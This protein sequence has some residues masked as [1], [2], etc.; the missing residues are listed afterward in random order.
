MQARTFE[1]AHKEW[2][3]KHLNAREAKGKER[4]EKAHSHREILLLKNVW[5]PLFHSFDHLYPEY[6]VPDFVD[7]VWHLDFAYLRRPFRICIEIDGSREQFADNEIR[8]D[9]LIADF[10]VVIRF[11]YDD[12]KNN[13]K[14]CQQVIL[15]VL[16]RLYRE[17][18]SDVQL[19]PYEKE[20][21]RL[22]VRQ[23]RP[24][25]PAD[26]ALSIRVCDKT[27]RALLKSLAEKRLLERSGGG[28]QRV[29]SYRPGL[30]PQLLLYMAG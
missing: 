12:I 18:V 2:L 1:S 24:I 6:E 28:K 25:T 19:S 9:H 22:S 21:I 13:P 7:G 16:G 26:V 30:E 29:R 8:Q 11:S 3:E 27:A 4:L 23:P 10:W 20:I 15:N 14:R 5:W 17:H